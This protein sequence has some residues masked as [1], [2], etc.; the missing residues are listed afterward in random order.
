MRSDQISLVKSASRRDE[1]PINVLPSAN[2]PPP[3]Q[4][5][6]LW[7]DASGETKR[8]PGPSFRDIGH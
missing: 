4:P 1:N 6:R 2:V 7:A 5:A 3:K 8:A